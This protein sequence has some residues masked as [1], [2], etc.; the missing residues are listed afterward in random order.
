LTF[1]TVASLGLQGLDSVL[2]LIA[3]SPVLGHDLVELL[4]GLLILDIIQRSLVQI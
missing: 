3:E 4:G 2:Q 1:T